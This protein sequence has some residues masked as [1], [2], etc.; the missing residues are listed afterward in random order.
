MFTLLALLSST[1]SIL[2]EVCLPVEG[3]NVGT[4][5]ITG[6]QVER[7]LKSPATAPLS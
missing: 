2:N 6:K 4:E 7:G 5:K 3:S 1:V